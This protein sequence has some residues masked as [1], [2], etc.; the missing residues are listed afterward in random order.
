MTK[1]AILQPCYIPWKGVF[2]MINSVDL[3][4]FFD[5]VQ[6]TKQDWRTRNKIKTGNGDLW[7]SVPVKKTLL[8]TNIC[9]IQISRRINWQKKHH[10]SII[11]NYSKAPF[12]KEYEYLLEKIYGKTTWDSLSDFNIYTTKL[13]A[14]TLGIKTN[15]VNSSKLNVQGKKTD[16]LIN[17][18]K[19]LGSNFYI[20]GPSAKNYIETQKFIENDIRLAYMNYE[21]PDYPQLFGKFNHFV[22]VLDVI[23]NCGEDAG[24]FIFMNNC[25][26]E[27]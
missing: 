1:I 25:E 11:S 22:T 26:V 20:S 17:I 16:R 3:F 7:L 15:F 4:V 21:Y 12:F 13:L 5:D 27:A 19:Q 8:K 9:D 6:F 18:C 23:F 14:R 2:D 10:K 24:K